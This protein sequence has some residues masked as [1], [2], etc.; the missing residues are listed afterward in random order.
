MRDYRKNEIGKRR[1]AKLKKS[2]VCNCALMGISSLGLIWL[3]TSAL[4]HLFG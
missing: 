3:A 1:H 2:E 4:F